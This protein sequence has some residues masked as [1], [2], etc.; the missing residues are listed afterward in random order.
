MEFIYKVIFLIMEYN[1]K[2]KLSLAFLKL[3]KI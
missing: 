3:Y 2:G 1:K